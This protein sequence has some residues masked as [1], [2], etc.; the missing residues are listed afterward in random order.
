MHVAVFWGRYTCTSTLTGFLLSAVCSLFFSACSCS[1]VPSSFPSSHARCGVLGRAFLLLFSR[2]AL[3][4]LLWPSR[5]FRSY[6]CFS[7]LLLLSLLCSLRGGFVGAR[8]KALSDYACTL[9][10]FGA[11]TLPCSSPLVLALLFSCPFPLRT[12]FLFVWGTHSSS[13]SYACTLPPL[14]SSFRPFSC[15]WLSHSPFLVPLFTSLLVACPFI[16]CVADSLF[17]LTP[18]SKS[19]VSLHA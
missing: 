6:F 10:C 15:V 9:L 19:V 13:S 14:L 16:L 5:L 4:L 8:T 1:L 7:A 3:C 17:L 12:H 18:K 11:R 2:L